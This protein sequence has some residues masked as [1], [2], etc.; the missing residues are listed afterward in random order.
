MQITPD[1]YWFI[2]VYGIESTRWTH[3]NISTKGHQWTIRSQVPYYPVMITAWIQRKSWTRWHSNLVKPKGGE[4]GLEV[5]ISRLNCR[6]EIH[7]IRNIKYTSSCETK[8]YL[9]VG[10]KNCIYARWKSRMLQASL[11]LA[12][13]A[14]TVASFWENE[15][16]TINEGRKLDQSLI[17]T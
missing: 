4:L 7:L 13:R 15:D 11:H 10:C 1:K 5:G 9:K 17:W 8:T 2:S 12:A 3:D 14:P 6:W 16:S